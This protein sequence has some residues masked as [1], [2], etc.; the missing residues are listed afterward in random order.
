MLQLQ[1]IKRISALQVG[2]NT[3][4]P[5]FAAIGL[6]PQSAYAI[7][8]ARGA[9]AD[10]DRSDFLLALEQAMEQELISDAVIAQSES[11]RAEIW[12]IRENIDITLRHRPLFIYDISLPVSSMQNYLDKL[13]TTLRSLW[14]DV[15]VYAYGHLADSNLHVTIA[16]QPENFIKNPNTESTHIQV[17]SDEESRWYES[18]NKIVFEPLTAHGGFISAEHG[19]GLL[20]KQHLHYSRTAEEIATM[21]LLKRSLDPANILNPGK[22]V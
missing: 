2:G 17:F 10:S 4:N 22:I 6:P 5:I 8:E 1:K 12:S 14:P 11:E 20:K 18:V 15:I 7:I 16:P 3:S 13:K 21:K 9:N 19:I